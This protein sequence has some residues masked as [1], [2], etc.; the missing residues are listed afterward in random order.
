MSLLSLAHKFG[1]KVVVAR[2]RFNFN[3]MAKEERKSTD[4]GDGEEKYKRKL[5]LHPQIHRRPKRHTNAALLLLQSFVFSLLISSG[6]SGVA[7]FVVIVAVSSCTFLW[8]V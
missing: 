2:H 8:L 6:S 1:R 3:Y 5:I 7:C 4:A